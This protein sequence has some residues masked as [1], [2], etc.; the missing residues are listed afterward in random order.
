[1]K[2]IKLIAVL[3]VSVIC[4]NFCLVSVSAEKS[5]EENSY[6]DYLKKYDGII[7]A[8][9]GK[10]VTVEEFFGIETNEQDDEEMKD[11]LSD[12]LEAVPE[13]IRND[14][15]DVAEGE[16]LYEEYNYNYF[17]NRFVS[18]F[19]DV[20]PTYRKALLSILG[21]L[22]VSAVA[23]VLFENSSSGVRQAVSSISC[24]ALGICILNTGFFKSGSIGF[25]IKSVSEFGT[26]IV[27][28]VTALLAAS[29]NYSSS[30]LTGESLTVVCSCIELIFSKAVFP[31]IS[32]S[33][34]AC[35]AGAVVCSDEAFALSAL[36]RKLATF[37]TVFSMTFLV[38]IIALQSKLSVAADTIGLKT[39]KFAVGNFVPFVGGTVSET[40]NTV[41]AGIG[42]IKNTCGALSLVVL[43]I[44]ILS[45]LVSLILGKTVYFISSSVANI[46]GCNAELKM[47]TEMSSIL[48]SLIAL[49]VSASVV[50][51]Y[52]LV[53][54]INCGVMIGGS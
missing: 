18:T 25:F 30:V 9:D 17:Y 10:K 23:G 3:A 13:Y 46:F 37:I 20:I 5:S 45:P 36:F 42:Y 53:F 19:L 15:P 49:V 48:N 1:M 38:F 54:V 39:I 26:A 22:L 31:L 52:I 34:S 27:P 33:V 11:Y 4:L 6:Y 12:F 35:L 50:F 41:G 7:N 44:L 47:L 40:L 43:F 29:G 21:I 16:N 28:T 51:V 8:E 24:A 14:L 32:V 2:K